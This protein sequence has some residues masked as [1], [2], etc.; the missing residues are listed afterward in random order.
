MT[1]TE[2]SQ[3]VTTA[4]RN[5]LQRTV[6]IIELL[7]GRTPISDE[8]IHYVQSLYTSLKSDLKAAAKT[9]TVDGKK[10]TMTE[11]ETIFFC[12]TA[13]ESAAHLRAPTN[14]HPIKSNWL[15]DLREIQLDFQSALREISAS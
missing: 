12:R 15:H 4:L 8:E 14:S 1:E 7:E 6:D 13:N 9:G 10:R 2:E 3:L 5:F 11:A